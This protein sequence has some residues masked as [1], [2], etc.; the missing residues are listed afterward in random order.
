MTNGTTITAN[1]TIY[2]QWT[3]KLQTGIIINVQN[4]YSAGYN[5]QMTGGS[6]FNI[7][8]GGRVNI[9]KAEVDPADGILMYEVDYLGQ[10]GWV[11]SRYLS[12]E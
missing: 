3:A 10:I 12:L 8:L 6:P 11:S 2:A 9:R 1:M 5:K 4:Y 7:P